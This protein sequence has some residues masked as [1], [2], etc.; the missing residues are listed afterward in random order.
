MCG[1]TLNSVLQVK[2]VMNQV[3][4]RDGNINDAI[5]IW[6]LEPAMLVWK[7]FQENKDYV[8]ECFSR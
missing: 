2:M 5:D 6:E 1:V 7:T 4:R 8:N 3:D